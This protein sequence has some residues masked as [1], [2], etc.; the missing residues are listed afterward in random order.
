MAD[1]RSTI[2]VNPETEQMFEAVDL[3]NGLGILYPVSGDAYDDDEWDDEEQIPFLMNQYADAKGNM[4][5]PTRQ[6]LKLIKAGWQLLSTEKRG[7]I[8][9]KY[10]VDLSSNAVYQQTTALD[11]VSS[12][13]KARKQEAENG[14][15]GN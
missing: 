6:Q 9:I 12:R 11:I 8:R 15:Q 5:T 1:V 13:G 3:G 2:I 14:K 4:F 7:M 10:W